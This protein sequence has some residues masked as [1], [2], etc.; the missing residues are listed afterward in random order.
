MDIRSLL[1]AC[2]LRVRVALKAAAV[3]HQNASVGEDAG[4][5]RVPAGG[6]ESGHA[7]AFLGNIGDGHRVCV[8]THHV[9]PGLIRAQR[10]RAGRHPQR[11]HPSDGDVQRFRQFHF[12]RTAHVDYENIVGV[13]GGDK[14]T[15]GSGVLILIRL[16]IAQHHVGG[17]RA[18]PN[19]PQLLTA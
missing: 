2:V 1:G 19:A 16:A 17:V 5:S 7:A 6:N 10:H 13:R 12:I 18:D 9:Q 3:Q 4:C 14:Q 11:M 15:V 8:G